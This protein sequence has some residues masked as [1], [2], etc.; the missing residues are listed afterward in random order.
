MLGLYSNFRITGFFT[1]QILSGL[2]TVAGALE[3]QATLQGAVVYHLV[4]TNIAM[5]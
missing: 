2:S 1:I 5:V 4:M 3:H